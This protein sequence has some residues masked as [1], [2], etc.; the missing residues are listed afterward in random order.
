MTDMTHTTEQVQAYM[1]RVPESLVRY[2]EDEVLPQYDHFDPAHQR[3]HARSVMQRSMAMG[4]H[5]AD[6]MR[7]CCS[8]RQPV[9]TLVCARGVRVTTLCR[10]AL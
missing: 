4:A 7:A 6:T 10:G 3:D 1:A 5:Y 9:T 8:R 2:L